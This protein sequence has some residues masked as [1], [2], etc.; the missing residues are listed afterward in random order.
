MHKMNNANGVMCIKMN[1]QMICSPF[2]CDLRVQQSS[3][4]M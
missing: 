2:E 4:Q 3:C 1:I